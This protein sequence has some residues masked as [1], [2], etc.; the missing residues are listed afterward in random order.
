MTPVIATII[1][2]ALYFLG[3]RFYSKYLAQ[4]VYKLDDTRPTP[5]HTLE[6]GVDYVPTRPGVLFGHHFASITGLAPMLGPAVAVIWGWVPA[7]IWVVLGAIFVGCVHDF[8]ALVMSL[9]ARGLSVGKV[10]EG[11]IGPRA[12]T[13]FLLIIFFGVALAMG[14]FVFVISKLFSLYIVP[15]SPKLPNGVP[16]HPEAVMPSAALMLIALVAGYL[17]YRKKWPLLPVAV[18]GFTLEL[19]TIWIGAQYPT[20][21][22]S[23]WLSSSTWIWILLGYALLASVLPVWVLLQSRDFL[24]GLLLYL[25]MGLAYVGLF[26]GDY[27]FSAPAVDLNPPG[28]P[29]M[30]P[31]VFIVIACGAA[32]GFHGLVSSGTT[33]KQMTKESHAR[34]IGYGGMVGESLLGLLAVLACTAGITTTKV[35]HTHY[36]SWDT[37]KGL[38]AKL[39]VFIE[40]TTDFLMN[41]GFS[42]TL[43]TALVAMVV[44]SFALTTLDSATRLMRFNIEELGQTFKIPGSRNRYLTSLLACAAIA[45]FAF[46]KVGGKPAGLALWGLFGTTNQLLASLTLILAT[47]YLRYR[48]WPTWPTAIPAVF[49][50]VSTL[51]AMTRNL[52]GFIRDAGAAEDA[53]PFIL[54]AVVGGILL[55]LAIALV[56]EAAFVFRRP[57]KET[58][59][60]EVELRL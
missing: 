17:L 32:S 38:A 14:V 18:V 24:N 40:G 4:K 36:A 37:A 13:L 42:E 41:L 12:R 46:F 54:L 33:A 43:G 55:S 49:M 3:Y 53:T 5:A 8:S 35:W 29:P 45:F 56:V 1:C 50:L 60:P 34:P 25:G 57:V 22:F 19:I 10:A 21:G 48:R 2:F 28:A 16:G 30:L 6:D 52:I 20:L 15:P 27:S 11:V 51:T 58:K 23:S 26:V 47:V 31:F 44:V 59:G 9:R 39:N 7:M